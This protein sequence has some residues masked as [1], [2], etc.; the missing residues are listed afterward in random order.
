MVAKYR[1][2]NHPS[3]F[4][5]EKRHMTRMKMEASDIKDDTTRLAS[6]C[7]H[8]TFIYLYYLNI[9]YCTFLVFS[10]FL[11]VRS[12]IYDIHTNFE[13]LVM[14]TTTSPAWGNTVWTSK[15]SEGMLT[16]MSEEKKKIQRKRE[17][18]RIFGEIG[19]LPNKI[20]KKKNIYMYKF[21]IFMLD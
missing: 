14:N 7:V 2:W 15:K 12:C 6:H 17:G 19:R 3:C 4:W 1:L 11:M 9:F 8:N 10:G 16:T 13:W 18:F 20:W 21:I 5:V